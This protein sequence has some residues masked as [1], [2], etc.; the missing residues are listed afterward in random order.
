MPAVTR[1][2]WLRRRTFRGREF[3]RDALVRTKRASGVAV[4]VCLPTL[5]V[6]DTV[7][8]IV[9]AVRREWAGPGGLVD[10]IVAIDGGSRDDTTAAAAAAGARVVSE[11]D[12]LPG[13]APPAGKGDALWRS[14]AAVR[15]DLVVWLDADV[16][17]FDPAFV[18]GLLGPLLTVPEV[19]Y[20]KAAYGRPLGSRPG[21]GG[22][23]TEICARPLLNLFYPDLAGFLQPLSGE[24]AGRRG[25][26]ERMPFFAGYA[27][28]V[29]LLIDIL[30]GHGLAA[31]AQVNLVQRRHRHQATPELGVMAHEITR[32]VLRRLA[33]DGR[34]PAGL[35]LDGTYVRP[36]TDGDGLVFRA[37]ERPLVERPPIAS[38]AAYAGCR[39]R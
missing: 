39:A 29:G 1:E 37:S 31:L 30:R 15:G 26:L 17:D 2:D 14:L 33:D 12:A 10:E 23:V 8:P 11:R 18:P 9:E 13:A 24:A 21:D 3:D 19:G 22:R 28:E 27:V 20:V 16:E 32:A 35:A 36:V 7:G 38:V 25:L 4:S 6:G 5:D 34:A